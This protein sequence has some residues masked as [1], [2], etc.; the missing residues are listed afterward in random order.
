M[1]FGFAKLGEQLE[2]CRKSLYRELREKFSAAATKSKV[3]IPPDKLEEIL[4]DCDTRK[5]RQARLTSIKRSGAE[6]HLPASAA[7]KLPPGGLRTFYKKTISNLRQVAG[8]L[9]KEEIAL[10]R[11]FIAVL[12]KLASGKAAVA[13]IASTFDPAFL[14]D[15]RKRLRLE[16]IPI[17]GKRFVEADTYEGLKWGLA[18]L[19]A[20]SD[21]VAHPGFI[22]EVVST[23]DD[24][25]NGR[26]IPKELRDVKFDLTPLIVRRVAG[27]N[28]KGRPG[29]AYVDIQVAFRGTRV[30]PDGSVEVLYHL[31]LRAQS[32]LTKGAASLFT[33]IEDDVEIIGQL[34]KDDLRWGLGPID[35]NGA[36]IPKDQIFQ[37]RAGQKVIAAAARPFTADELESA[38]AEGVRI[39]PLLH[40]H[41]AKDYLDTA[42]VLMFEMGVRK[43][44]KAASKAKLKAKALSK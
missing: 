21:L 34:S 12:D 9:A 20:E 30:K 19:S 41:T 39:I 28:L 40:Q 3:R 26:G 2:T 29:Q 10:Y 38:R 44:G 24:M 7:G 1:G 31:P 35:L 4:H 8:T 25:A 18:G 33:H 11:H 13:R 5:Y 16:N 42:E 32:K 15:V 6:A 14:R 17:G 43:I 22:E 23:V 37:P 27:P 36:R